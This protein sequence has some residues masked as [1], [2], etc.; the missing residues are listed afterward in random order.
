[1]QCRMQEHKRVAWWVMEEH[2]MAGR[3]GTQLVAA[4]WKECGRRDG[5]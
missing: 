2:S 1:M 4:Y 5:M 3:D